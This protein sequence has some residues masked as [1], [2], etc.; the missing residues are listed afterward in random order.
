MVAV[1]ASLT[2]ATLMVDVFDALLAAPSL[3]T[4]VTER[5]AV[6]GASDALL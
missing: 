2:A 5:L 3:T 1:G 4:T 6:L